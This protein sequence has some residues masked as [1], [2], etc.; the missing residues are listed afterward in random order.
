MQNK[1]AEAK[2]KI[3]RLEKKLV[4]SVQEKTKIEE[5]LKVKEIAIKDQQHRLHEQS[6]SLK[7]K[8]DKGEQAVTLLSLLQEKGRFLDF[9]MDDIALYGDEQV[10]SASRV[11]HQG[12]SKVLK[13]YFKINPIFS[14]EE[15]TQVFLSDR[16]QMKNIDYRFVGESDSSTVESGRL[17]HKGWKTDFVKLPETIEKKLDKKNIIAPAEIEIA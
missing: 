15:G 6:I 2:K 8:Q 13:D 12:C 1:N 5:D 14:E 7:E 9:L 10:G 3:D 16:N 11:V 4:N 17:L